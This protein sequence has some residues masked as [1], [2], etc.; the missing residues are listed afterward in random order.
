IMPSAWTR[1]TASMTDPK[2]LDLLQREFQPDRVA[3]F[4]AW[5]VHPDTDVWMQC[6]RV[7][8]R[9]ASRLVF[10]TSASTFVPETTPEAWAEASS[11]LFSNEE[12]FPLRSTLDSFARELKEADPTIDLSQTFAAGGNQVQLGKGDELF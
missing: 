4:V 8:G 3:A 9:G 12:L 2:V 7:S 5:L 10:C 6:F 1:M 11:Q